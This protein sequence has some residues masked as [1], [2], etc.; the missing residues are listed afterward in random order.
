MKTI[1]TPNSET[2]EQAK[3]TKLKGGK[4]AKRIFLGIDAH[5][6]SYQVCRKLD[7]SGMQPVQSFSLEGLELFC[8]KQL[9]LAEEVYV[10]YEAVPLGYVLY[11]R[12]TELGL[13]AYVCALECLEQNKRKNN[14]IDCRKLTSRLYSLVNGDRYAMRVV[15]VPSPEQEILRAQ[16]RQYDQLMRTRKAIA[17]QGRGLMLSQ[18]YSL[19][20]VWWRPRAFRQIKAIVIWP[21]KRVQAVAQFWLL[22]R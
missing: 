20:G 22:F 18:G 4:I 21:R 3:E 2:A 1:T 14:K 8:Y 6:R 9:A 7:Q 10:V 13:K 17:A 19:K 11:R 16:S 12:L 5:V 15:R